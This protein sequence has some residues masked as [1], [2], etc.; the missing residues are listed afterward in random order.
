[1]DPFLFL[2]GGTL[3]SM[4]LQLFV[5]MF[6][7]LM[8]WEDEGAVLVGLGRAIFAGAVTGIFV[9]A[10]FPPAQPFASMLIT[11]ALMLASF[12][13]SPGRRAVLVAINILFA[14]GPPL[15]RISSGL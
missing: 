1:M 14:F 13:C 4:L 8:V 11:S 7:F 2:V 15:I 6:L 5:L 10:V 12:R 9:S 3:V